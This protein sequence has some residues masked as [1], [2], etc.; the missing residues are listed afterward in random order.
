MILRPPR[1]TRTDTLFP[2]T[3][4]FRSNR[5]QRKLGRPRAARIDG[6][7]L[8]RRPSAFDAL[9]RHRLLDKLDLALGGEE[10][11]V[12]GVAAGAA[13]RGFVQARHARPADQLPVASQTRR[14]SRRQNG[15]PDGDNPVVPE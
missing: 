9:H 11:D 14:A 10:G 7:A 13:A 8:P 4:L 2:Y 15:G 3:T 6:V 5:G 1:S 12:A